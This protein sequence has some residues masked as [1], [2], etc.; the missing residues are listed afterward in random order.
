MR[1]TL[2]VA[3]VAVAFVLLAASGLLIRSFFRLM[4]V[5]TGMNTTSVLTFGLPASDKEYPD[6]VALNSYLS[7]LTDAVKSV[8][9]VR[10]VALSCAPP[11]S[12]SFSL[13]DCRSSWRI[14]RSSRSSQSTSAVL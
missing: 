9:G 1:D 7:Q 8:A 13:R 3:E 2:V 14:S 6:P 10:A 12:G 11:M 5:D 4:H